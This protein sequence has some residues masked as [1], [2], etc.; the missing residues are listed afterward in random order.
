MLEPQD[1]I[2][3][4]ETI[5]STVF[6]VSAPAVFLLPNNFS[7]HLILKFLGAGGVWE[8]VPTG[9]KQISLGRLKTSNGGR[10]KA[11]LPTDSLEIV[12]LNFGDWQGCNSWGQIEVL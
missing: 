3:L 4:A 2:N 10:I 1:Q 9:G 5:N 7:R 12:G 6:I 8:V 11:T